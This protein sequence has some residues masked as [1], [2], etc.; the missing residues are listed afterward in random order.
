M[1]P[2][3]LLKFY[4]G[5]EICLKVKQLQ[6]SREH[7][8]EVINFMNM[9][10]VQRLSYLISPSPLH[11]IDD[12]SFPLIINVRVIKDTAPWLEGCD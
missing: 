5:A 2:G 3:L 11:S 8:V 4:G 1:R 9:T 12:S 10:S 6:Y 7:S